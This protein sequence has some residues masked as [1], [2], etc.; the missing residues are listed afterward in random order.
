MDEVLSQVT[1]NDSS[2]AEVTYVLIRVIGRGAFGEAKLYRRVEVRIFQTPFSC[3]TCQR[4][5]LDHL[6]I[7]LF[8]RIILW[9]SGRR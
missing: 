4:S 3:G 5:F 1:N 7:A 9:L 6:N 2:P 8:Y